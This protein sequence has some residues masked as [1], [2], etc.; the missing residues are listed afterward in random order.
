MS[1]DWYTLVEKPRVVYFEIPESALNDGPRGHDWAADH[2]Q[3]VFEDVQNT[4]TFHVR[5][6]VVYFD[7]ELQPDYRGLTVKF[8]KKQ[9]YLDYKNSNWSLG[10]SGA[11]RGGQL[12]EEETWLTWAVF[13]DDSVLPKKPGQPLTRSCMKQ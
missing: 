3:E 1:L 11:P 12:F 8:W 7:T 4:P 13:N 6:V 5:L 9:D 10:H 2:Y